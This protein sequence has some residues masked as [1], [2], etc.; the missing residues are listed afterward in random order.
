MAGIFGKLSLR[1]GYLAGFLSCVGLMAAAYYFEYALFL[2]PCPLC[3]VQRLATILI[4]LGFLLAFI[5]APRAGQPANWWLRSALLFTL[6]A[7]IFGLWAAEHHI[8]IQN[9]PPEDVPACGPSFEYM[10]QTLPLT[11]LLSIMLKG[12]GNCAEVNWSFIGLSMPAWVLIWFVGFTLA[13]LF[14]LFKTRPRRV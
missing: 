9:L 6:A 8:W 5:A 13:T 1:H 3:M 11:D 4:G 12:N 7:C 2:D 14:A 10:M